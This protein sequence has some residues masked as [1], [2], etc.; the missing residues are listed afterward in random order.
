M[1]VCANFDFKL[2]TAPE[3]VLWRLFLHVSKILAVMLRQLQIR[4]SSYLAYK[5]KNNYMCSNIKLII[6]CCQWFA[7]DF[8]GAIW[9]M[10]KYILSYHQD[11]LSHVVVVVKLGYPWPKQLAINTPPLSP[12]LGMACHDL[13]PYCS[14]CIG[15][16]G[17]IWH[18]QPRRSLCTL[19]LVFDMNRIKE[20]TFV[21]QLFTN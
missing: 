2:N 13:L 19:F 8:R 14:H 7:W 1:T 12:S 18:T 17:Y 9:N 4:S 10:I 16:L 11:R 15:Y 5:F 20:C 6:L 21:K 3:P